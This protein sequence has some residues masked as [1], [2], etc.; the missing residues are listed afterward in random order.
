[1]RR[2]SECAVVLAVLLLAACGGQA[3]TDDG[4]ASL[5]GETVDLV[6]PYDPGGGYDVYARLLAPYLEEC[7]DATVVVKNEPGAGGLLATSKTFVAPS[8]SLRTVL[9]N[10]V[11]V[12]SAQLA[13]AEGASFEAQ[14]FSWLGRVSAEPN[15]LVV[16][17]D[18]KF[19]SFADLRGSQEKIRF[20]A[21]GPGSN[22]YV[23]ST[24]LPEVYGFPAET[25]TGFEGSDAARAAVLSGDADAHILPLDSQLKAIKAGDVKPLLVI[26]DEPHDALPD[27]ATT[28]EFPPEQGQEATLEALINLSETGRSLAGP[29]EMNPDH[30]T[31]LRAGLDCALSNE[32]L[33]AKA[34]KQQRD[35]DT[36]DGEETAKVVDEA[37]RA[38]PQFTGL[39]KEAR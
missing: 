38:P 10:T 29:P 12:V 15:V 9:T 3:S 2:I 27:V 22:E 20:V 6:V 18:S 23:N 7:L 17:A 32:D 36:L 28:A 25:V 13:E 1:M 8:D 14:K 31:A 26:S 30:L 33:L 16:A 4:E 11:G 19:E 5:K 21:T 39:I 37:L 34:E 24:V 35:I